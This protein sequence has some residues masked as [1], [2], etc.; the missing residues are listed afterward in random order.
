[1]CCIRT[2]IAESDALDRAIRAVRTE[3]PDKDAE[4]PGWELGISSALNAD[5]W[6]P[7]PARAKELLRLFSQNTAV[8]AVPDLFDVHL[9]IRTGDKHVFIVPP[10]LVQQMD[11]T[12]RRFFRPL[13]DTIRRGRIQSPQFLFYPYDNGKLA[14]T[15]EAQLKSLVPVFYSARLAPNRSNLQEQGR[16]QGRHWWELARP[17]LSWLTFGGPRLVSTC[18][19][20]R[21][22][23]AFDA[24]GE[25]AVRQG[26]AWIW[27][28]SGDLNIEEWFAYLAVLNSP[29]FE[30][31]LDYFCPRVQGGQYEVA[32]R[33]MK[34]VPLPNMTLLAKR[35]K[36]Q[37]A[38][39]GRA[40]HQGRRAPLYSLSTSA[41]AAFGVKLEDFIIAF[42]LTPSPRLELDFEQLASKWKRETAGFS[43]DAQKMKHSSVQSILRMG[44][45]AIPLILRDLQNRPAWWFGVLRTLTGADPVPVNKRGL[46]DESA[47]AWIAWGKKNGYE[48]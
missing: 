32:K 15:S 21:G 12:E 26:N 24:A 13:A 41:A 31:V 7:R 33:F 38:E 14:I 23:F 27:K 10:S 30:A 5:D 45:A 48:L 2:L 17:H 22:A 39:Y 34:N 19:A 6:N 40:I 29:I 43:S 37:L 20:G 42:P 9:G 28:A 8:R 1:V 46:L 44:E 11:P 47:A 18:F 36:K 25:Y 3:P 16:L 4:G 35:E